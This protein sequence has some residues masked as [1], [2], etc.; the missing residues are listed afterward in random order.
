[1]NHHTLSDFRVGHGAALDDLLTQV[2]ASLVERKLVSVHRIS[3]DGTRVRACC[4]AGSLRRRERFSFP[5][6]AHHMQQVWINALPIVGLL[7]FLSGG[8]IVY[9]GT[10]Q[11]QRFGASTLAINMVGI[12]VLREI[13]VLLAALLV[14]GRSGSFHGS[15]TSQSR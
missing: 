14:G 3:Q 6:L 12:T 13:G 8:V 4:G 5:S 11:L 1:M 9:Q 10:T 2:I 15:S 7:G